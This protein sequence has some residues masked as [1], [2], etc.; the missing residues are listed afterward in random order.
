MKVELEFEKIL[1]NTNLSQERTLATTSSPFHQKAVTVAEEMIESISPDYSWQKSILINETLKRIEPIVKYLTK[2]RS[3]DDFRSMQEELIVFLLL[4]N[5]NNFDDIELSRHQRN[6][7]SE[8]LNEHV[9]WFNWSLSRLLYQYGIFSDTAVFESLNNGFK[10]PEE[11]IEF[12]LDNIEF[13][14]RRR[15]DKMIDLNK[16]VNISEKL[17]SPNQEFSG[18]TGYL[19]GKFRNGVHHEHVQL[20]EN[21]KRA[22]G[23]RG[24]LFIGLESEKSIHKRKGQNHYTLP[25]HVRIAQMTALRSVDYVILHDP[26]EEELT[27]LY[28][29]YTSAQIAL[30]PNFWFIGTEDYH[31]RP[32]FEE[33]SQQ[34]G[35]ILLWD[36]PTA[37]VRTS[38]LIGEKS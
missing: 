4:S 14:D 36:R 15:K 31:W 8:A 10:S 3:I 23:Y 37:S 35:S 1:R 11:A 16:A 21:A 28:S 2:P 22:L 17:R 7:F 33:I 24:E 9:G 20:I 32:Q 12:L 26:N 5:R 25:D 34:I 6:I 30:K 19:N 18:R 38:E 27:D 29:F 13:T